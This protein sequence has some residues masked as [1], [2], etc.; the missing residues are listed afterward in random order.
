MPAK[1]YQKKPLR[2]HAI[3]YRLP[4]DELNIAEVKEFTADRFHIIPDNL[5]GTHPEVTAEV[6]DELHSTWVGVKNGDYIIRGIEG[7][8]YPHD[9]DLF[10]QAYDEVPE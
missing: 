9:G 8:F 6:Y 7:E 3:Q 2:I 4:D 1:L 5:R 10:P